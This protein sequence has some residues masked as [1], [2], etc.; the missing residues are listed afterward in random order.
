MVQTR[1]IA[2]LAAT[3]LIACSCQADR[4]S[5]QKYRMDG[6]RTGVGVPTADN[7]PQALGTA[8]DS[9]YTAP[10]GKTFPKGGATY[11]VA[12]D[13]IAVQPQMARLKEV[14]GTSAREMSAHRPESELS[15]WLV[16]RLMV[17]VA[18]LTRKKVD[19]GISNF[20]GIRVDLPKGDVLLDD[21]VSMFPFKNYLSYVALKGSDLQ[22]IFDAMAEKGVQVLGGVK[23]VVT[24]HKIDTLLVGGKPIDPAKTYGVATIDFLLDGGDGMTVAKNAKELIITDRL[25]IDAMLPYARSFAAAG[26]PIDYFTD[27]RVVVNRSGEEKQ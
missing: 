25:I 7:V 23:F 21:L 19:V 27:G 10:N 22:A 24:D 13:M 9:L 17:E 3:A 14:I 12:R 1:L 5:W 11:A 8:D 26:K 15:N 2:L 20:G 18:S 6:H 4:Y 16:D